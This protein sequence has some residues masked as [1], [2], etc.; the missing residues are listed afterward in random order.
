MV[1]APSV[2]GSKRIFVIIM[3]VGMLVIISYL[4]KI[5]IGSP[6]RA[7]SIFHKGLILYYSNIQRLVMI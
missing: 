3:A 4:N 6:G 2:Y 1:S 7:V 5:D